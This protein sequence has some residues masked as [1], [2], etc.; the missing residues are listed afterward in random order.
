MKKILLPA[1]LWILIGCGREFEPRLTGWK[2]YTVPARPMV[3]L[4]M[5][6]RVT[7]ITLPGD[8]S[9]GYRFA[10]WTKFQDHILLTQILETEH[11]HDYQIISIDTTGAILDTIYTAPPNTPVNFKLAPNDSLLI[12]KTYG[13]NCEDRSTHYQYTFYNRYLKTGLSDTITVGNARGILLHET[14]WSPDSKKV[15]IPEWSGSQEEAFTYDLVTKDTIYIDRGSNFVWSPADNNLVAYIRDYSIYTRDIKTG[16]KE[17]IYKGNRKKS[18]T[19]FR[20]N[21]HGDF[22]MI[23]LK[24]Y[25]LNIDAAPLQRH[26]IIYLSPPD[27]S[28]SEVFY[29]E[30]RVDTWKDATISHKTFTPAVGDTLQ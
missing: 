2:A 22:L 16:E 3:H 26:T 28:E 30:Q 20:W 17:L 24:S 7:T 5:D 8:G 19:G 29:S 12:I 21:P 11:C 23:H 25:F 1:I 18:V 4:D 27:R 9:I 6:G 14:V 15:I 13:D 10:Q